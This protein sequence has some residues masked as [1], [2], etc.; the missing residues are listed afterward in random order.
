MLVALKSL[1]HIHIDRISL[2]DQA[3]HMHFLENEIGNG[4]I[5]FA[6][7]MKSSLIFW[8][9][10]DLGRISYSDYNTLYSY[11]FRAQT[12]APYSIAMVDNDLFWTELKSNTIYWSHR[13]NTGRIKHFNIAVD[14]GWKISYTLP[15]CIP[16]I[17]SSP[18][19]DYDHL[20]QHNNDGC[21]HI[22]IAT[23]NLQAK[24]LC[25]NGWVFQDE[26]NKT[27]IELE[28]CAFR[29]KFGKCL[30][31]EKRCDKRHDCPG[32]DTS[33][34]D[35]CEKI[36]ITPHLLCTSKQF[37]C[38]DEDKCIELEKRCDGHNDCN[39]NSDEMHCE[40]YG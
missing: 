14:T 39:D 12:E 7:D 4:Y 15:N 31:K 2:N 6:R 1:D 17:A 29:C 8:S 10:S 5:R 22:C 35:D 30:S 9:D 20:C 25:P 19:L 21:S 24:C 26:Y 27:C 40:D 32:V 34:E 3:E 16:I 38:Q 23:S 18:I 28:Q 36:D 13:N 37:Y 33:D 11:T